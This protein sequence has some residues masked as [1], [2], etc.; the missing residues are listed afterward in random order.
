MAPPFNASSNAKSCTGGKSSTVQPRPFLSVADQ[1]C[2][3]YIRD[4]CT[5]DNKVVS[6]QSLPVL[7][8]SSPNHHTIAVSQ[9]DQL[10]RPPVILERI[11]VSRWHWRPVSWHRYLWLS[12][13]GVGMGLVA[14]GIEVCLVRRRRRRFLQI[15]G[16][17][18]QSLLCRLAIWVPSTHPARVARVVIEDHLR[19]AFCR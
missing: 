17:R 16:K 12:G 13:L 2:L 5:R 7:Q 1:T 6:G 9:C 19:R 18:L 14:V 11:L 3:E 8:E 4:H 10:L 15:A